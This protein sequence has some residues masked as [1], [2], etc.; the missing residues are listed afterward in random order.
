MVNAV[1]HFPSLVSSWHRCPLMSCGLVE[2]LWL[3]GFPLY[4][5]TTLKV[6]IGVKM[7]IFN[8]VVSF[9]LPNTLCAY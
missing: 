5:T 7:N 1:Y 2:R 8:S 6:S 3:W 9:F 4:N